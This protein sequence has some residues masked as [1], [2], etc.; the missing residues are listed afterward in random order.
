MFQSIDLS[1][2]F[3]FRWVIFLV[4]IITKKYLKQKYYIFIICF[5]YGYDI[6]HTVQI[7]MALPENLLCLKPSPTE[8]QQH[9]GTK[10]N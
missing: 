9:I 1:S 8:E 2:N 7:N 10:I 3:Y 4:L 6:T 5:S